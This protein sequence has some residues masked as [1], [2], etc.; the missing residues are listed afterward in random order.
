MP[1]KIVAEGGNKDLSLRGM[2]HKQRDGSGPGRYIPNAILENESRRR[3]QQNELGY[4]WRLTTRDHAYNNSF[5]SRW[6]GDSSEAPRHLLCDFF[7]VIYSYM[8]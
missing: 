7:A 8:F 4:R 5:Q 6:C 3:D 1:L 2:R